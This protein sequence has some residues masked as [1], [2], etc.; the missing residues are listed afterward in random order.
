[1]RKGDM[2]EEREEEVEILK[3]LWFHVVGTIKSNDFLLDEF[4]FFS[5]FFPF[6]STERVHINIW[7]D[8]VGK[9]PEFPF[10]GWWNWDP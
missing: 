10:Y 4:F 9:I 7:I 6:F 3:F 2:K 5:L 8:I 1:M